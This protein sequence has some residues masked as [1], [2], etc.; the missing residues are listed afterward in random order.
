MTILENF[1]FTE[2]IFGKG[3][4]SLALQFIFI[5]IATLYAMRNIIIGRVPEE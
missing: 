2:L 4:L 1:S 3:F 5:V